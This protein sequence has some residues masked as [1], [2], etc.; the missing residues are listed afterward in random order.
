[1]SEH[2]KNTCVAHTCPQCGVPDHVTVEQELSGDES[3][4]RC[5]CRACGYSWHPVAVHNRN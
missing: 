5:H 1:M 3:V 2:A 4:I